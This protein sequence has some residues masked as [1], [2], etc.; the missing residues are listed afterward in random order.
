MSDG[1][2]T[3]FQSPLTLEELHD[4]F[5]AWVRNTDCVG[6]EEAWV[7]REG[8]VYPEVPIQSMWLS[9]CASWHLCCNLTEYDA[10]GEEDASV[11]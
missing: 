4:Q 2:A 6:L 1:D 5:E 8:E 11:H 9:W 10:E 3:Y 7:K